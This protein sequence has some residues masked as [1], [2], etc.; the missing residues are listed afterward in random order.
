MSPSINFP[1]AGSMAICPDANTKPPALTAWEYGP[2]AWGAA[3]RIVFSSTTASV[4]HLA[5]RRHYWES[6]VIAQIGP[7]SA[8]GICLLNDCMDGRSTT[9][10]SRPG[11]AD[12]S[13]HSDL[14]IAVIRGRTRVPRNAF[15]VVGTFS[16]S[17]RPPGLP[18]RQ[19][20]LD[21]AGAYTSRATK[22]PH[23]SGQKTGRTDEDL[24]RT[25]VCIGSRIH[26]D[27]CAGP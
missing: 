16:R 17:A 18:P 20:D 4:A 2:I 15:S 24:A 5:G 21:L 14:Q 19:L 12:R 8:A 23:S 25:S 13:G 10:S 11:A 26:D 9:G 27:L 1:V 7:S 22:T 6:G 3:R